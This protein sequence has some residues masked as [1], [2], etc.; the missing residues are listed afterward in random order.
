MNKT[1]TPVSFFMG[2]NCKTG[3]CSLFNSLYDP[4]DNGTHFLLKGGP[5][6][7]KSTLMKRVAEKL[8][9]EGYFVERGYCSADPASL[10]VVLAP[11]INFS[12]LDATAPHT[13]DPTLPGV[14]EHIVDL[15]A[16]FNTEYL[17]S[18]R[19]EIAQLVYDNKAL[20]KKCADY[21]W[22]ASRFSLEYSQLAESFVNKDK[23]INYMKRLAKRTIPPKNANGRGKINKRFL[24]AVS[25]DGILVQYET[26]VAL[27]E[28]LVT[29]EDRYSAV[30]QHI[31]RY[32]AEYAAVNGYDVYECF[33]PYFPTTK[34]EHIIIPELK[35]CYFSEN[36][37][38][39]SLAFDEKIV[40]TSRFFE[41]G[42]VGEAKEKL[43]YFKRAEKDLT[44]EAV[45]KLSVAKGIHDK[46]EEYYI[47]ATDFSVVDEKCEK[48][49]KSI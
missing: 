22:V 39:R 25:P 46:L 41:N 29:I 26:I 40:H 8:E 45:K 5:G 30:S 32:I 19:D 12:V 1:I 9:K 10:D 24:S 43:V 17:N 44:D 11:E 16:A 35:I 49:L 4:R 36:S 27:A 13:F 48:I 37:F 18:H 47:K 28:K 14:T 15:G 3:Y 23:L 42:A 2:A 34:I 31:M 6:S 7:G 33:C 20:H 21:M 38:H